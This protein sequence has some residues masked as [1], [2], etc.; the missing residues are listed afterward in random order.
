MKARQRFSRRW[1]VGAGVVLGAAGFVG[2]ATGWLR[3]QRTVQ[4]SP[5][6]MLSLN[7]KPRASWG[8]AQ[9]NHASRVEF[10]FYDAVTNRGGWRIYDQPLDQILRTV[11]VHHSALPLSDGPRE[12]QIHHLKGKGYADIGYHFV[13]DAAGEMFEGRPLNVRGAHAGGFNT[14]CVGICLLGNFEESA[15]TAAQLTA[16]EVLA[17]ALKRQFGITHLAGHRDFQPTATVCPGAGLEP[18]LPNLAT[19]LG[20]QFGTGGYK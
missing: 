3:R 20:L 10:G 14:G 8:A 7:I 16:L 19:T 11:V 2:W 1:A 5:L 12:I 13:I 17:S 15:P 4:G 6:K 9:P 18:L